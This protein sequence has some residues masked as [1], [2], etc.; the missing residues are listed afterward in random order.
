[1]DA[2]R[3]GILFHL[4]NDSD[5]DLIKLNGNNVLTLYELKHL[6]I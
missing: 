6:I 4:V 5:L 2:S 1:M 3:V